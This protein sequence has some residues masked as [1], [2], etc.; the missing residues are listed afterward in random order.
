MKLY[1]ASAS[2]DW[3][4]IF[5]GEQVKASS[6]KTAIGRAGHMAQMRA[7]KRPKQISVTVRL[8]GTIKKNSSDHLGLPADK[9]T[10]EDPC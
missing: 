7:R 5:S 10:P 2:C 6:F 1:T 3:G 8:V 9:D 4:H